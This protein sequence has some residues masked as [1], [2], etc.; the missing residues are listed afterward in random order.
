MGATTDASTERPATGR[1]LRVPGKPALWASAPLAAALD[2]LARYRSCPRD[3]TL[4]ELRSA[5]V[6]TGLTWSADG[7]LTY[8]A[9]RMA[10]IAEFDRLVEILGES[11]RMA[12]LFP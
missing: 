2:G 9:S 5:L 11:T 7:R 10:L 3:V 8:P 4:G 12:D 6:G 1:F